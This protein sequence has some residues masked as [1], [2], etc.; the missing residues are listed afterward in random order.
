LKLPR[1]KMYYKNLYNARSAGLCLMV[2][3]VVDLKNG[4]KSVFLLPKFQK[5]DD[6]STATI[7]K[8]ESRLFHKKCEVKLMY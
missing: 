6:G 7:Y 2:Q 8:T 4:C 5:L 3:V 1:L